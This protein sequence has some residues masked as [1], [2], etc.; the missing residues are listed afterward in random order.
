MKVAHHPKFYVG[1]MNRIAI[2]A[3][4]IGGTAADLG[5]HLG[6]VL[7][8]KTILQAA[9]IAGL[10]LHVPTVMWQSRNLH[11]RRE[12]VQPTC[13][14]L[15][16]FLLLKHADVWFEN[17]SVQSVLTMGFAVNTFAMVRVFFMAQLRIGMDYEQCYDRSI[18]LASLANVPIVLGPTGCLQLICAIFA[19]NILLDVLMP[20]SRALL[21]VHRS[22]ADVFPDTFNGKPVHFAQELQ[23]F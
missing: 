18:I 6:F 7:S 15:G 11:G 5:G 1:R 12:L 20:G 14:F 10:F 13:H 8:D 19:W 16:F 3:H 17:G 21:Q 23:K 9:S 22:L 4:V 2:V